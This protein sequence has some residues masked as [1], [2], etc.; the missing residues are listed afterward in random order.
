VQPDKSQPFLVNV[1]DKSI[2]QV[3]GT[4]FNINA[5]NNE[6][7]I[8]TTL[9]QGAVKVGRQ[10]DANAVLL[11]PGEQAQQQQGDIK[12]LKDVDQQ[13]VMAWRTGLFDFNNSSLDE[14]M[15]EIARWY[16]IEVVYEQQPPEIEFVGKISRKL[17][18][19]QVLNGLQGTGF[20]FRIENNRKLV[21][22]P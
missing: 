5:Y 10:A 8:N 2:V 3:L 15:R 20:K 13:K 1:N 16:D 9:L 22:L 18:L 21:I 7:S 19:Q 6:E 12:V 14:V 17:T 11:K 4:A